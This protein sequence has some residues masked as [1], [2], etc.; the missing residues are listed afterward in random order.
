MVTDSSD[1]FGQAVVVSICRVILP[2]LRYVKEYAVHTSLIG[3]PGDARNHVVLITWMAWIQERVVLWVPIAIP[4][5][6]VQVLGSAKGGP[7]DG[8]FETKLFDVNLVT[9]IGPEHGYHMN[10]QPMRAV[11]QAF[12]PV[13][14]TEPRVWLVDG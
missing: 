12:Q 3:K 2:I 9:C 13:Q 14:P 11:D 5:H 6:M 4:V 8:V 7:N 10:T 1:E